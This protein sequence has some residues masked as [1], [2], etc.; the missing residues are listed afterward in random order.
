MMLPMA[1]KIKPDVNKA[2][3][4]KTYDSL[5]SLI[6]SVVNNP[7][8]Y[9]ADGTVSTIDYT[10]AP[11]YNTLKVEYD[12]KTF[13]ASSNSK[14]CEIL[15]YGLNADMSG[16]TNNDK[17]HTSLTSPTFNFTTPNGVQFSI[18]TE[19]KIDPTLSYTNSIIFDVNGD[20]DPNCI[21]RDSDSTCTKPDRFRFLVSAD[22][23]L[24]A[25]DVYG[26]YYLKTRESFKLKDVQNNIKTEGL[27]EVTTMPT[28]WI[29]TPNITTQSN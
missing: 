22:G 12:G 19:I 20:K 3:Y 24:I 28:D 10:N 25:S 11:L 2:M 15:A 9:P 18:N 7:I 29:I 6:N 14:F 27:K 16:C 21:G 8:L 4:I 13:G 1:N 17:A 5:V 26:Q 23:H